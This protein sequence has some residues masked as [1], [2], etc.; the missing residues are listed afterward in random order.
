MTTKSNEINSINLQS[1]RSYSHELYRDDFLTIEK[2]LLIVADTNDAITYGTKGK[3]GN[4][5]EVINALALRS[6]REFKPDEILI[7]QSIKIDGKEMLLR[8]FVQPHMGITRLIKWAVYR[9]TI[10]RMGDL[11]LEIV[12]ITLAEADEVA[13][14]NKAR[15]SAY[16]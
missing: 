9:T 3:V 10:G 11:P 6:F 4:L 5:K 2:S 14:V 1:I 13:I 7:Y 15:N 16:S 12:S 8:V